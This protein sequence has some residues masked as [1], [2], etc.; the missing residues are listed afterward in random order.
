[1]VVYVVAGAVVAASVVRLAIIKLQ[2]PL[3][4]SKAAVPSLFGMVF[5][6]NG[7]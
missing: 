7:A 3:H 1:M 6:L 5:M 2:R 4:Q